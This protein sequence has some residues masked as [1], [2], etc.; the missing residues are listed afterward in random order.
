MCFCGRWTV[1][2]SVLLWDYAPGLPVN[3]C[4]CLGLFQHGLCMFWSLCV[5]VWLCAL[6]TFDHNWI[7]PHLSTAP[8]IWQLHHQPPPAGC[9][10]LLAQHPQPL[11]HL[12]NTNH[13]IST[14]GLSWGLSVHFLVQW[15]YSSWS[16]CAYI[17]AKRK[18]SIEGALLMQK[19]WL[20][21]RQI[22]TSNSL[23]GM[24]DA[25]R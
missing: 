8:Q 13:R 18:R 25:C 2:V 6:C 21:K 16:S 15:L 17:S 10:L 12:A 14:Q 3:F 23:A 1:S 20:I 24:W 11:L 19:Q 5:G 22:F 4:V 7:L 9:G